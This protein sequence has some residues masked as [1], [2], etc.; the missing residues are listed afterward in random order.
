MEGDILY[1]NYRDELKNIY[2]DL[3]YNIWI[4]FDYYVGNNYLTET[5]SLNYFND[6]FIN[7]KNLNSFI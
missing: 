5:N 6:S 2:E 1:R 3:Y 7:E 4:S